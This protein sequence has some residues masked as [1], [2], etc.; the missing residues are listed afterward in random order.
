MARSTLLRAVAVAMPF[1]LAPAV[2]AAPVTKPPPAKVGAAPAKAAAATPALPAGWSALDAADGGF[3]AA[4]P[5]A[6]ERQAH[7]AGPV[8]MVAYSFDA[9]QPERSFM[10][11]VMFGEV[12]G[13]S[14]DEMLV[15]TLEQ[16][17]K[18]VTDEAVRLDGQA[19]RARRVKG[20]DSELAFRRIA[21]RDR[22]Y[23]FVVRVSAGQPFPAE[24]ARRFF[25]SVRFRAEVTVPDDLAD[26]AEDEA[27]EDA[28]AEADDGDFGAPP[29]SGPAAVLPPAKP[30]QG[31]AAFEAKDAGFSVKFPGAPERAED[32]SSLDYEAGGDDGTCKFSVMTFRHDEEVPAV[33]LEMFASQMA[34]KFGRGMTRNEKVTVGGLDGRA[35][36]FAIADQRIE[37]RILRHQKRMYVLLVGGSGATPPQAD[38]DAFFGSFR[39]LK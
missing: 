11:V 39:L 16:D 29:R 8:K 28:D 27:D 33:A 24:D 3:T 13:R 6:P 22:H 18:V 5:G 36:T 34:G 4:F 9:E 1:L 14:M 21:A 12:G 23:L 35:V 32:D 2:R 19:G 15:P 30:A 37:A 17:G 26:D 38:L 7:V 25:E 10:A 31:F 20:A